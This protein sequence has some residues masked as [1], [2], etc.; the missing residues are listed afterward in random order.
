MRPGVPASLDRFGAS[1]AIRQDLIGGDHKIL[2]GY[3]P[4]TGQ[5]VGAAYLYDQPDFQNPWVA[6]RR[7]ILDDLDAAPNNAARLEAV[8][9]W[10]SLI[11]LSTSNLMPP[12]DAVFT[13]DPSVIVAADF[14]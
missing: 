1:L 6:K 11:A 3:Q 4:G 9:A 13:T 14:E 7:F 8:A 12:N 5:T 10:N 2:I